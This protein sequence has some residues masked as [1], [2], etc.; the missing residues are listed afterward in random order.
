MTRRLC[1]RRI[2][3][4]AMRHAHLWGPKDP[5][6]APVGCQRWCARWGRLIPNSPR[7][8][9]GSQERRGGGKRAFKQTLIGLR[10]RTDD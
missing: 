3:R 1:L 8:G 6:D 4:R 10:L 2:M 5:G 9:P 7:A